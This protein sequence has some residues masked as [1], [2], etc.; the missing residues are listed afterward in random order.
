MAVIEAPFSQY[1]LK[2]YL[3]VMW[4]LLGAAA[5]FAYDGYL[6]RYEW[7]GRYSFY[8]KHVV[9]NGGVPDSDMKFNMYS[10]PFLLAGAAVAAFF[11]IRS[12]N[13]KLTADETA[14][15]TETA[16]IPYEAIESI[17][18]THF[19]KKGFFTITYQEN[20]QKRQLTLSDRNYDNLGALLDLLVSKLT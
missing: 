20:A 16:V 3:I 5:M 8:K 18:K 14:L 19:D 1:K 7:S 13:R 11:Y 6:S 12:K 17:D 4:I 15:R 2:N 9:D 10:P